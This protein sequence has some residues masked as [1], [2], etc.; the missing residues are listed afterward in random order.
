MLPIAAT[1]ALLSHWQLL[2]VLLVIL[3]L[4]GNRIPAMARALG[5]GIVEFKKG[6][7]GEGDEEKKIPPSSG[8]SG[9]GS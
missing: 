5:S 1:L 7:R 4:F 9:T 6:L 2:I 3:L 8:A